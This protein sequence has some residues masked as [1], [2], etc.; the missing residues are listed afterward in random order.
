MTNDY[1]AMTNDKFSRTMQKIST[2]EV[3]RYF[4]QAV[5]QTAKVAAQFIISH[6]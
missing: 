2:L 5:G 4:Q 6:F 3:K 1:W